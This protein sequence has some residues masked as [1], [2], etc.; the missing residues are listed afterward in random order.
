MV[1]FYTQD[2]MNELKKKKL[3]HLLAIISIMSVM[4]I[5]NVI[6]VVVFSDYPYGSGMRTTFMIITYVITIILTFFSGVYFEIVYVPIRNHYLKVFEVL[7]GK[8]DKSNVT[9]LRFNYD[10]QDKLGVKF[11]S[12]D[13]ITWSDIQNDYVERT[14]IYDC[15]FE[16]TFTENQMVD[17]ITCGNVLLSYEVREWKEV[18]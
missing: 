15:D 2:Y 1:N 8:K 6:L 12:F 4:I 9:I 7:V 16:P 3:L 11:K 17:V 10:E 13:A 5:T 14:I 18:K